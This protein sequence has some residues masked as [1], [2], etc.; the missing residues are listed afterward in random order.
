MDCFEDNPKLICI[1]ITSLVGIAITIGMMVWAV[2]TVEPIEF[3]L[4]YNS[5]TKTVDNSKV[6]A[7]GWYFIGPFASF[8]TF[9]ATSVNIDFAEYPKAKSQPLDTKAGSLSI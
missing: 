6:Y 3:G 8:I 7:G 5:I 2:G 4:K 9:P 1:I